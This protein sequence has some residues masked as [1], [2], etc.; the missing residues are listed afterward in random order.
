MNWTENDFCTVTFA[1]GINKYMTSIKEISENTREIHMSSAA[2]NQLLDFERVLDHLNLFVY[3]NWLRGEL[4]SGPKVEKYWVTCKFMWPRK[5][6]P[7]PAG[8]EKLLQYGCAVAFEKSKLKTPVKI[9][10]PD[11]FQDGSRYPKIREVPVWIVEIT[12]PKSLLTDIKR[13]SIDIEGEEIDLS[14]L[15]KAYE[16]EL[17]DESMQGDEETPVTPSGGTNVPAPQ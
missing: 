12:M 4:V 8:A 3:A 13:G 10:S 2:L 11:D 14:D 7:D 17:G 16:E 5:T 9:K 15:E 1:S 6:M